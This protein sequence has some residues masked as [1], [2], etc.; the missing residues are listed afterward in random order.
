MRFVFPWM[1]GLWLAAAC[2]LAPAAAL[3]QT[4]PSGSDL[5][6]EI[7]IEG[8]QR[9]EPETARSYLTV[10]LGDRFDSEKLDDS[11]KAL[12]AT[13]LFADVILRREGDALIVR[14]VEN[15]VINRVAFE[16]NKKIEDKQLNDEIQLKTRTVYSRIKVQQDV[17][18]ILE[19]YRKSGRFS[20]TVEPK[21]I[22][23]PENRVDLVYEIDEGDKTKVTRISFIGNRVFSDGRLRGVVQTTESAWWRFFTNSDSYDPDRLTFDRELLR[24][25]YLASGYADFR[26]ISAVAEL[27]PDKDGFFITFT[28]DEGE[29]YRFGKI[30]V[31]STVKDVDA[32]ELEGL[33]TVH[34]GDWY[35]ADEVESTIKQISDALGNR[36]YAFVEVRPRVQRDKTQKAM[37]ITFDVQEGPRVYVERINIKGNTRTLDK[38]IR[39]ELQLAEGDAFNTSKI[40][41]SRRRLKNLGF[42]ETSDISNTPGAQPDTTDVT[43]EVKEQATGEVSLGAGYSTTEGPIGDVGIREKNFLGTGQD[44]SARFAISFRT[45]Q[46]DTSWTDPYFLDT[47]I[48]VGADAFDIQQDL[49]NQNAFRQVTIGGTLRAGYEVLDNLRQTWHYTLRR[50][51]IDKIDPAASIFIQQQHGAAVTSL[52]GQEIAFDKR[53][54]RTDPTSGYY[55]R[56]DTD[57]AGLGGDVTYQRDVLSAGYY[58]PIADQWVISVAGEAGY[59]L[60]IAKPIRVVDSFFLGGDN[61]PGFATA[62]IGPRDA[63]SGDALGGRAYYDSTLELTVPLGLPK[64]FGIVGKVFT[65]VGTL[66]KSDFSGPGVTDTGAL[67]A[68]LGF[69]I[70]WHSPFGPIRVDIARP[71]LKEPGDKTQ[72]F[73]FNFG[74]RF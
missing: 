54:S 49:T 31:K 4:A 38:V 57:F 11:L 30:D 17:K 53:D 46:I 20:A 73:R 42:F 37:N 48:A 34:E 56:L 55:W 66:T 22:T 6:R 13:G 64:E 27:S 7:R 40:E 60:R 12:Y 61:F 29:R 9:I 71:Y 58:Y 67:R 65:E 21:V 63:A 36:G 28:L 45:Q 47:N 68:S 33:V 2:V 35:N 23:L 19:V 1:V 10:H 70:A 3:A 39:R 16:G 24:K 15:P 52:V 72:L 8:T 43:V 59:I 26:V 51:I 41:E 18:R 50:D 25:F 14:I 69:G 44:L 5:I 62:G 74:T 32:K